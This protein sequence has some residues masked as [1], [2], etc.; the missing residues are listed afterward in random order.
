MGWRMQPPTI[1]RREP[2]LS[3][4]F[5]HAMFTSDRAR[6][7]MTMAEVSGLETV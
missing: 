5:D 4:R 7:S 2:K 1:L 3:L 6:N